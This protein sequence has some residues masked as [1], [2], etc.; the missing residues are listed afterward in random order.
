VQFESEGSYQGIASAMPLNGSLGKGFSR[1][2]CPRARSG[3][4]FA[5]SSAAATAVLQGTN[6]LFYG[7]YLFDADYSS[8]I[9]SLDLGLPGIR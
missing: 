6:G 9:Y 5:G 2:A 1:C 7:T 4:T 3:N 8:A